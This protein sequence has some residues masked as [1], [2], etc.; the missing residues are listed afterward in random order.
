VEGDKKVEFLYD[1]M[2]RRVKKTV[3]AY[4]SGVWVEQSA[5][6]FVY[7][8]WNLICELTT[9]SSQKTTSEYYVWG[10]YLSGSLQGAGGVSGLLAA[11]DTDINQA[12]YYLYDANGNMSQV[13]DG[14]DSA[15]WRIMSMIRMG[16]S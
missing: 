14:S 11:V 3:Y 7:D 6:L 2:G 9:D 4:T 12:Y 13:V 1:Y 8:G 5:K 16:I 10:L 15:V